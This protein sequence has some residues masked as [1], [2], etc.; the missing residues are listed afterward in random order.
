MKRN[1][2]GMT[3]F[4]I[5]MIL[6]SC[7][8]DKGEKTVDLT[9]VPLFEPQEIQ[10]FDHFG[11]F[12]Y[13]Y[14]GISSAATEDGG[15]VIPSWNPAHLIIVGKDGI[16]IKQTSLGKGPGEFIDVGVPGF[17]LSMITTF[18]QMQKKVVVLDSALNLIRE[19]IVEPVADYGMYRV[20]PLSDS[21]VFIEMMSNNIFSANEEKTKMYGIYSIE[22]DELEHQIITKAKN[23][24]PIGDVINS[25]SGSIVQ[26]PYS[27]DQLSAVDPVSETVFMFDTRT[28]VIA[29]QNAELDTVHTIKVRVPKELLNEADRDSLKADENYSED[30][31]YLEPYLAEEKA[32]A[33]KM[34]IFEDQIWLQTNLRGEHTIWIV[35]NKEGEL[36]KKVNLP[37]NS[38]LTHISRLHLGV[39]L[40]EI[41]F[42]L[43]AYPEQDGE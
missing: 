18:D 39:R 34:M 24:A 26:V 38:M 15:F 29:E 8:G 9:K 31:E 27:V 32:L 12:Y 10:R 42:A 25:R 28:D 3:V 22:N 11:D 23:W 20:E 4:G 7:A 2:W 6:I 14:L 16:P 35:L 17:G 1:L 40:N 30:W 33:E 37:K 5:G 21:K 43:F 19:F 41:E 36:I 13:S